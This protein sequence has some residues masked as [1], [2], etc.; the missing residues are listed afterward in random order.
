LST[1]GAPA[2]SPTATLTAPATPGESARAFLAALNAGELEAAAHCFAREACLITP[3][4]TA[5]RGREEI[6]AILGQL[7]AANTRIEAQS[8]SILVAGD[9]ALATERWLIHTRA[10][11]AEPF[12][13]LCRATA[14]LRRIEAG[15]KLAIVAP[16]G[17]V[18]TGGP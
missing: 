5:I 13:R 4:A 10:P 14:V 18:G 17:A 6:R 3:D 16:W 12:G 11:G 1:G 8:A 15:W 9:T 7:I 2:P